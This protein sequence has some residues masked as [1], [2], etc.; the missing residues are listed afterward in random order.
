MTNI[1]LYNYTQLTEKPSPV[2]IMRVNMDEYLSYCDTAEAL[3]LTYTQKTDIKNF[4]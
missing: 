3:L 2:I 4:I 1:V